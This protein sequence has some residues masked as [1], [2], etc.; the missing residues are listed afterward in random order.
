MGCLAIYSAATITGTNKTK[1]LEEADLASGHIDKLQGGLAC[2]ARVQCAM[3]PAVTSERRNLSLRV[4]ATGTCTVSPS[5]QRDAILHTD[6]APLTPRVCITT[7]S[8]LN[9]QESCR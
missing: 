9:G 2:P 8:S 7:Q 6:A 1:L 3:G 4:T 5:L